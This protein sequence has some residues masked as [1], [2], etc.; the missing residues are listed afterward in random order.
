MLDSYYKQLDSQE[1]KQKRLSI[2]KRDDFRCRICG[3]EESLDT[4]LNVHHRYYLFT[5]KAWE[6]DDNA[7]I[8]LCRHCHILVHKSVPPLIYLERNGKL[9]SIK[10]TPCH[11]CHGAGFIPEFKHVNNGICFRCNGSRYDELINGA[12]NILISDFLLSSPHPFDIN[13]VDCTVEKNQ[14]M[15]Q[16]GNNYRFG[17]NGCIP[18]VKKAFDFY[19]GAA[20]Y[21]NRRAL[22]V[23]GDIFKYGLLGYEIDYCKAI[24][25]YAYAALQGNYEVYPCL[26]D[27][28]R[29]GLGVSKSNIIAREWNSICN[30]EVEKDCLFWVEP[31]MTLSDFATKHG[32]CSPKQRISKYTG[33]I[34]HSIDALD[35]TSA[36]FS[37]NLEKKLEESKADGKKFQIDSNKLLI[38]E[39]CCKG[40]KEHGFIAYYDDSPVMLSDISSGFTSTR[41]EGIEK[42]I[43]PHGV[44]YSGDRKH[45]IEFPLSTCLAE[46]TILDSCEFVDDSAFDADADPGNSIYDL[47]YIGN[48]LKKL[49]LP[50]GLK[51]I[52]KSALFGCRNLEDLF[53]PMSV[54][55]IGFNAFNGCISLKSIV[56]DGRNPIYDSRDCCNAVVES[57]SNTLIFGC[58]NTRISE[59]I[60]SIGKL[61]F[62][63]CESLTMIQLPL[64]IETIEDSA[65]E[66]CIN[67]ATIDIPESVG[68]MGKNVFEGCISLKSISLKSQLDS[69]S[70]KTFGDCWQLKHI[71]VRSEDYD[72]YREKFSFTPL[73]RFVEILK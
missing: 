14:E 60:R 22:K 16:Q 27:M 57:K 59:S 73:I 10:F 25:W 23:L 71:Y 67:L 55:Y 53:V 21:G 68:Y 31:E 40:K 56:V 7:L 65:F 5:K 49:I 24:R 62:S 72:F 58:C 63:Y 50:E 2:L 45:L 26:A 38:R 70:Y 44:V 47:K 36:D 66:W 6:Y 30:T 12:N 11:R 46:Y 61:A 32:E 15:Y 48:Q 64:G 34:I 54:N 39:F 41:Y 17:L 37:R 19:Y 4:H 3:K 13:N 51:V 52:S 18:D 28:F 42:Y 33:L 9:E 35:G 20:V 29:K 8:T 43:D 1:W 69:I